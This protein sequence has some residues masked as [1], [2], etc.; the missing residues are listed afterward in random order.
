MLF[1]ELQKIILQNGYITV[2]D[3][4]RHTMLHKEFGYYTNK[5]PLGENGDFITSPEISQMFGEMIGVWIYD[6]WVQMGMP[7]KVNIIEIGPGRGIMMRDIVRAIGNIMKH[8]DAKI[9]MV[10]INPK[11]ILLQKENLSNLPHNFSIAWIDLIEDIDN[12][13]SIFVTNEFFDVLPI[14]QYIKILDDWQ[15][16]AITYP[17]EIDGLVFSKILLQGEIKQ[18]LITNYI[19]ASDGAVVEESPMTLEYIRRICNLLKHNSGACLIIDYGYDVEPNAR[20]AHQY[21][22][23]LQAIQKHRYV[24]ILHDPS[25]SDLSSHVDFN[26]IKKIASSRSIN[27]F[28]TI[29]QAD[30]LH[31]T[32]I[33]LRLKNLQASNQD[34]RT[35]LNSQYARLTD[36]NSMGEIFKVLC[37]SSISNCNYYPLGM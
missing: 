8:V 21:N 3:F 23:T 29:T 16:L 19:N 1:T 37:L 10:D 5:Q 22:S 25:N 31:N 27:H 13:P 2:F 14:R 30:F 24:P 9:Y 28:G 6:T 18:D 12:A 17:S 4:L 20:L 36:K 33:K 7:K 35:I 34:H 11:L 26:S 15:E 32:G